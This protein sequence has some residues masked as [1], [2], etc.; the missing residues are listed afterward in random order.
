[1]RADKVKKE[2]IENKSE[3]SPTIQARRFNLY[4]VLHHT[5]TY[6]AMSCQKQQ[7]AR[8][9]LTVDLPRGP[10]QGEKKKS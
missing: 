5:L 3:T 7:T 8:G 9:L 4:S 10:P 1:M 6:G 2:G